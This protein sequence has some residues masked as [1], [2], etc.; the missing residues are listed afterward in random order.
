MI[1]QKSCLFFHFF[2]VSIL[3]NILYTHVKVKIHKSGD[4]KGHNSNILP[5]FGEETDLFNF[6]KSY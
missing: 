1:R 5:T 2:P 4:D 6:S 3:K